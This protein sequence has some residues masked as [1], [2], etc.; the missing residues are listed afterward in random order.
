M[1]QIHPGDDLFGTLR[2]LG[3]GDEV[4][5]HAGTYVTPG[6]YQATWAGTA[7]API[8][9]RGAPGEP[10][11][12]VVGPTRAQNIVDVAGSHFTVSHVEF[13]GGS[14]GL[15]LADVDHATLADLVLH[16][17]GDVGISCNRP[18]D[19]CDRVTIR[20]S[21]IYDTGRL[22]TGEGLYLGCQHADCRF[23]NGRV[24]QNVVHDTGGSQGDG[25]ELKPGS[26]GNTVRGNVVYRTRFPGITVWGTAAAGRR[27]N[28]IERNVVW[29]AG[30]GAGHIAGGIWTTGRVESRGNVVL[31]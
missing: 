18:G 4:M 23:E 17:L 7:A 15:R 1:R 3:P 8:V 6:F 10:R 20:G 27:P 9:I 25:I 26:F 19:T 24:E 12:I 28:A 29:H 31:R 14:H 2:R 22:G 16:D 5:I 13:R 30:R 11:P 21:R